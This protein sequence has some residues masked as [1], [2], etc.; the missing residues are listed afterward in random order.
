MKYQFKQKKD[1]IFGI[2]KKKID[3]G[4]NLGLG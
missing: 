3:L 4:K 1:K 2:I